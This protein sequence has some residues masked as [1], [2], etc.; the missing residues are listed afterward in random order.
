VGF[1]LEDKLFI[2]LTIDLRST[3]RPTGPIGQMLRIKQLSTTNWQ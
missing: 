2:A 1:K 3:K